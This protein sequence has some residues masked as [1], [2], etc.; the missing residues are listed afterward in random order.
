[1]KNIFNKN[2]K[3]FFLSLLLSVSACED[4]IEVEVPNHKITSETVFSSDETAHSA[5]T[6]IYNRLFNASFSN[7]GSRSVTFLAGLTADNFITTSTTVQIM[8]FGENAIDASNSWNLDLWA[9][10]YNM[11]YMVNAILENSINSNALSEKTKK[12]LEGEAKFIRAF[13]YFQLINLFGEV[14]LLLS[15]DYH[16]NAITPRNSITAVFDQIIV[17]L[18]D[19]ITLLEKDYPDAERTRPNIYAAMALLARTHL[20]LK[21]WEQA[22]YY[23]SQVIN[24]EVHYRLLKNPNDVFLANSEE[25]IW[26]ISPLGWGSSFTHTNEGNLFI[27]STTKT[28]IA[29]LSES[30]L[31]QWSDQQ[32]LRWINW[33]ESFTSNNEI[34]FYPHKYKIQYDASGGK[35]NEYSMVMRLAEQYLIRA[36]ANVHLGNLQNAIADVDKIRERAEIVLISEYNPHITQ[37]ELLETIFKERRKEFFAEWGHRWFD[38]KR[39]GKSSVLSQK[40]NTDWQETD[41]WYPIPA[42]ERLKNPK[43]TQ[44][45]GY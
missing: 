25:A 23:S 41:I 12:S 11:I 3:L 30:F 31:N 13:T 7:G 17:D 29:V 37:S 14:P 15:T 6:G 18:E 28:P 8:E 44:N 20:Y 32:D 34:L 9:G 42:N 35:I 43:L 33:V 22:E 4:F 10:C 24:Q 21:N 2:T 26:Q 1:M 16:K 19:A 5:M 36:E 39:S 40:P 27:P 45:S 38:L